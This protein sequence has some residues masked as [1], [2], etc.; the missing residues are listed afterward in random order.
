LRDDTGFARR[1]AAARL[2]AHDALFA[3]S[4]AALE[5]LQAAKSRGKFV[6]LDQLDPGL[7]EHLI[8]REEE[9][10]F[11]QL[12][13]APRDEPDA[14]YDRMKAEWALADRI[15]VNSEWSRDCIVKH[16]ATPDKIHVVPLAYEPEARPAAPRP[17]GCPV[18]AL[19]LGRVTL[20]KGVQ[21]LLQAAER[22][23]G[24]PVRIQVAGALAIRPEALR[25]A[26]PNVEWFGKVTQEKALALYREADIF[27][28]P[29]LSDGFAMTQLEAMAH[30]VPVVATTHCGRVV[31]DGVNGY[32]VPARDPDALAAALRRFVDAPDA[33]LPMVPACLATAAR[34]TVARYADALRAVLPER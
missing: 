30:G 18:R 4:Y 3:F 22:L 9:R 2:P 5:A 32:L 17:A 11:P 31:E 8:I 20:Q 28:L 13:A 24:Q 14:Y 34:F 25:D 23:A 6:I 1:V 19:W 29:T 16:G 27:V 15:V 7:E 21:Y 10:R 12:V 26:P 33:R